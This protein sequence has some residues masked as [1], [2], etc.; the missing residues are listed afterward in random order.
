MSAV[1]W[2]KLIFSA[3][4]WVFIFLSFV[5]CSVSSTSEKKDYAAPR[6]NIS[7]DDKAEDR[8]AHI[9]KNYNMTGLKEDL[10]ILL[11]S[12]E[13]K[14][15][16]PV[17]YLLA[18]FY[19]DFFA[20]EPF[21]GEIRGIAKE[22][23]FLTSEIVMMN[24]FYES[25]ACTSIIV[26]DQDGNIYH[27]RNMDLFFPYNFQDVTID[28]D[29][30]KNGQVVYTGTTFVGFVGLWTGQKPYKFTISANARENNISMLK[31]VFSLIFNGIPVSWLI[32]NTLNEAPDYE[33]A[34]LQLSNTP[35]IAEIY[36]ILAGVNSGEG[37]AIT[38]DRQ[39][40]AYFEHLNSSDGT[41]FLVQTNHDTWLGSPRNDP[42]WHI[43][44]QALNATGQENINKDTLYKVLSTNKVLNR[45]TIHTSMMNAA[46]PQDYISWIRV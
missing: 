37:I 43:A 39:Y 36:L 27:G 44:T 11:G 25:I 23:G 3:M 31:N 14:W 40:P 9:L 26:E 19:L 18:D 32:R 24:L 10:D 2:I 4:L 6:Y 21:A 35:I 30:I 28:V 38:R 41:W 17:Y 45:G 13:L 33:S 15:S 16:Q 8:W 12:L 22:T 29:F 7:L 46:S 20:Q 5:T 34:V 42:R 1:L